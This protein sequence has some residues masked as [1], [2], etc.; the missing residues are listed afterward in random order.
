LNLNDLSSRGKHAVSAVCRGSLGSDGVKAVV[1]E[2]RPQYVD[3]AT[4]E[5]ENGLDVPQ[6]LGS[7]PQVEV[8]GGAGCCMALCAER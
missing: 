3:P 7:F 6:A 2:H 4:G 5:G 1:A 8:S